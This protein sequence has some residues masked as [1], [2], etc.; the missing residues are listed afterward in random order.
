MQHSEGSNKDVPVF[1][2]GFGD[3]I[4]RRTLDSAWSIERSSSGHVTVW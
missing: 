3:G 2:E 4:W 1:F